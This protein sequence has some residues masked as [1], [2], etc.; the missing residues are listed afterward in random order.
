VLLS[1][2]GWVYDAGTENAEWCCARSKVLERL[3]PTNPTRG[4]NQRAAAQYAILENPSKTDERI[5]NLDLSGPGACLDPQAAKHLLDRVFH[6]DVA[7][8]VLL[9]P[10]VGNG[11]R[12]I[13]HRTEY[14]LRHIKIQ[15]RPPAIVS[16]S[17]TCHSVNVE[18]V[19]NEL[20]SRLQPDPAEDLTS[21]GFVSLPATEPNH[22]LCNA[23]KSSEVVS[24]MLARAVVS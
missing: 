22:D 13:P 10:D 16:Q 9:S 17:D 6:H 2:K 12:G 7:E 11:S 3:K 20:N 23:E 19:H 8:V 15:D 24:Y 21:D 14:F 5:Q 18:N 1:E 4:E